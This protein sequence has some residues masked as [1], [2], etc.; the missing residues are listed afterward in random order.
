MRTAHRA[1]NAISTSM[2]DARIV[3]ISTRSI[4]LQ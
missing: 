1:L 2:I 3:I 4:A